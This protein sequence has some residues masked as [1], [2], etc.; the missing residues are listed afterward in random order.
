MN[1]KFVLT[2]SLLNKKF[3]NLFNNNIRY[4]HLFR[5]A[6]NNK[7]ISFSLR[8]QKKISS[9]FKGILINYKRPNPLVKNLYY[10]KILGFLKSIRTTEYEIILTHNKKLLEGCTTNVVCGKK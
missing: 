6:I 10:K 4:N 3:K 8:K 5:I 1:I 2:S 7:K 9:S